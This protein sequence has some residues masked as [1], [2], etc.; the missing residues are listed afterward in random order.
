MTKKSI[1]L[2]L[3]IML[4]GPLALFSQIPENEPVATIHINWGNDQTGTVSLN[5]VGEESDLEQIFIDAGYGMKKIT[6]KNEDDSYSVKGNIIKLYGK[7]KG[8][9]TPWEIVKKISFAEND[10]LSELAVLLSPLEEQVDL[11]P[12]KA[13]TY[14]SFLG[15][16]LTSFDFS[17][18]PKSIKQLSLAS[19]NLTEV[20]VP[21]LPNLEKLSVGTNPE[22]KK[23]DISQVPQLI[24]LDVS[25]LPLITSLDLSKH[26]KLTLLTAYGCQLSTLDLSQ[27]L[28]IENVSLTNN[29]LT[30]VKFAQNNPKLGILELA[31]NKLKSFDGSS[32]PE[33]RLLSLGH[34]LSLSKL[35]IS[36]NKD[37]AILAV[38]S[39]A[40]SSIDVKHLK[41]LESLNTGGCSLTSLDLSGLEKLMNLSIQQC[42]GI[43]TLN[44][45]GCSSLTNIILAGNSLG[46]DM[47]HQ[48]ASDLPEAH[49]GFIGFYLMDDPKEKNQMYTKDVETCVNKGFQVL[50]MSNDGMPMP[51]EGIPTSVEKI[52]QPLQ[53]MTAIDLG[54]YIEIRLSK[55]PSSKEKLSVFDISG[56]G[57][58][59][60]PISSKTIRIEKRSLGKGKYIATFG[61][62]G[63]T[64]II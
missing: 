11:S 59:S 35:D 57:R 24:E 34:N 25:D 53:E 32:M 13:L 3:A 10:H 14:A 5:V 28:E 41:E 1:F 16:R 18:L 2:F 39:T 12:C 49:N 7:I 44:I 31:H 52:S 43:T 47:S 6:E 29:V 22:L 64:F 8:L 30:D 45:S 55:L 40:I 60:I 27:C 62:K 15:C 42:Y 61:S 54:N 51:Y 48:I 37:L 38:D 21:K 36:K 46:L 50:Q 26:T 63:I 4:F 23:L 9:S 17:K 20:V 58:L 33:L 19:N 56:K